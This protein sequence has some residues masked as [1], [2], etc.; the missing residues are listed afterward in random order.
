[1]KSIQFQLRAVTHQAIQHIWQ[2]NVEPNTIIIQQINPEFDGEFTLTLFSL[3]KILK[4]PLPEIS[5]LLATYF[6]EHSYQIIKKTEFIKGFLNIHLTEQFY[7]QTIL[8]IKE[9]L[10]TNYT[11]CFDEE[12]VLQRIS[13][14]FS[15][16]N[17]NKPLHLGHL[18][19]NFLGMAMVRILEK[20]GHKVFKT[21]IVNDRGIHICKTMLAW[22]LLSK[23]ETPQSIGMKGDHFV[24][25]YYVLFND[26]FKKDVENLIVQGYS[27]E[28]AEQKAP[29]LLACQEMLLKWE[30]QD[31]DTMELWQ[32][33]NSWV[34]E[35]FAETYHNIQTQFDKIFYESDI[36]SLGKQRIQEGIEQG[37]FIK[38]E[39]G[40][41]LV[42]LSSQGLDK[43]ILQRKD[44]TAVYITQDIA[45]AEL[46]YKEFHCSQSIYVVGDEQNY[47]FV[48]LK[49]ILKTLGI[50]GAENLFH[51]SYGMVEL[52]EG[53]MK[54]REGTVVDA[55]D[56]IIELTK[57]AA[58]KTMELNKVNNFNAAELNVLSTQLAI[59]ALKFFLLRVDAK[60]RIVFNSKESLEF[61]GCTGTF[62]QYSYVRILSLLQKN[63]F[64]DMANLSM[65]QDFV[66]QQRIDFT[67]NISKT[68]KNMVI[69]INNYPATI[70]ESA[71]T[72]NPSKLTQYLYSL[73]QEFNTLYGETN[74][75]KLEDKEYKYFLL[76]LSYI[77]SYILKDGMAIIGV[78]MPQRM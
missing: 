37:V 41:V 47:H 48:V 57:L 12:I 1:M 39:T 22:K 21:C 66:H 42:D 53:K 56:L 69:L 45:L 29:V 77:T 20:L 17:T 27:R 36:Y 52:P 9:V 49:E 10:Q 24:G 15:S 5:S 74:M 11:H 71:K 78:E 4:K 33:M 28:D 61:K 51:L 26:L 43:K 34:Y 59:G 14:E 65:G 73:A 18:R 13:L 31:A 75:T 60:S 2:F 38:D 76:N 67:Q 40:A 62:I 63:G 30:Q 25:K 46:K 64:Q 32:K 3:S 35:G 54:S 58:E 8:A 72:Y 68:I 6:L 23:G 19:N 55:D 16:P 7:I 70:L 50:K 44:G